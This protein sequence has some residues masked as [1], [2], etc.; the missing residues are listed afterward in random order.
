VIAERLPSALLRLSG[1]ALFACSVLLYLDADY[2]VLALVLLFLVPDLSFLGYLAGPRAGAI[3]YNLAHA[4]PFALVLATVGVL[5]DWR[6]GTQLGLIWT[7]H[8]GID[9]ALGYGFKYPTGFGD[10]HFQR[11]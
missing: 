5:A 10:T 6:L 2:S 11:V 7:A 4:L 3:A 1:A 9:W 8:V